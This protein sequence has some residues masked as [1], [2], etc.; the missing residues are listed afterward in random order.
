MVVLFRSLKVL[1]KREFKN[2]DVDGKPLMFKILHWG[3][4]WKKTAVRVLPLAILSGIAAWLSGGS[5]ESL[6]EILELLSEMFST[7]SNTFFPLP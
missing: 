3:T 4:P 5:S 7:V 6:T 1:L 2:T